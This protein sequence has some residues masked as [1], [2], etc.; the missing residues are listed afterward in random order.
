MMPSLT[1]LGGVEVRSTI[2]DGSKPSV[3][4]PSMIRSTASP[5]L[6][7]TSVADEQ[8]FCPEGL[9]LVAVMGHPTPA[10]SILASGCEEILTAIV[11]V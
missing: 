2:V 1:I 5:M 3:L 6:F 9:A 11:S 4:P 7:A 10:T 8:L